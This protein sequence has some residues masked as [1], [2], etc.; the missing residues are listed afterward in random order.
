MPFVL[1]V[2]AVGVVVLWVAHRVRRPQAISQ[3]EPEPVRDEV[4]VASH[5]E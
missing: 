1:T 3:P 4:A 5:R 2:L